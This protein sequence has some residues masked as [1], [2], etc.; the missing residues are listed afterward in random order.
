MTEKEKILETRV[1]AFLK[2]EGCWLVKYWGGGS[3][4]RA[5]VPDL[6]VCCEGIFIGVEL[7]A[8]KG[9]PSALQLHELH[10]IRDAG[11]LAVL[12]YPDQLNVFKNLIHAI[13]SNKPM[14]MAAAMDI[15]KERMKKYE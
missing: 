9:R 1:K 7:K 12:L 2:S 15:L 3:Y 6:L 14:L 10:T 11:G 5:G 4:T 8:E 13:K